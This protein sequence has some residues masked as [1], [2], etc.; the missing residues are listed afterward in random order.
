MEKGFT[1]LELLI[2]VGLLGIITAIGIP[3]YIGY[4]DNSNIG[5]VK[6]NLRS[7]YLAEQEY[8]R[9]NNIYY[10]TG[11]TCTDAASNINTNLFSGQ[12]TI[13]NNDFTYCITQTTTDDFTA[14]ASEIDGTRNFT[15]N[16]L[17]VTNF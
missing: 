11:A 2:V 15:I 3:Q 5:L 12:N 16:N 8:Y 10:R 14:T 6:N 13:S 17:N 7:I 1:L 4:V 9:K